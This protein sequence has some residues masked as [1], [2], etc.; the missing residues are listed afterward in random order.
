MCDIKIFRIPNTYF[1]SQYLRV[2]MR[3]IGKL[4]KKKT[5]WAAASLLSRKVKIG[6]GVGYNLGERKCRNGTFCM[7]LEKWTRRHFLLLS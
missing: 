6:V 7:V 2:D 1:L 5:L 3:E 4:Q